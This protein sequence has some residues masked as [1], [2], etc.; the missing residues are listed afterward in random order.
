MPLH[1]REVLVT[2]DRLTRPSSCV[3]LFP[4]PHDGLGVGERGFSQVVTQ[5]H[6]LTGLIYQHTIDT[7]NASSWGLTHRCL[8]DT[9]GRYNL[10]GAGFQHIT[11]RPSQ[12]MISN[13]H[14][15]APSVSSYPS[16]N[17]QLI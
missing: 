5:L 12:P 7:F 4:F 14:L 13:F 11:P 6:Q 9:G 15:R 3:T 1:P 17:Y 8:T 10:G 16:N 2:E